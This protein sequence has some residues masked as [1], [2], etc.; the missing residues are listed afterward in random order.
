M[1]WGFPAS[2]AVKQLASINFN[3]AISEIVDLSFIPVDTYLEFYVKIFN[4]I[5]PHTVGGSHDMKFQ[6]TRN[7]VADNGIGAGGSGGYAGYDDV[8]A[9]NDGSDPQ[10]MTDADNTGSQDH[11]RIAKIG[12]AFFGPNPKEFTGSGEF[13]INNICVST[14]LRAPSL[15]YRMRFHRIGN[16]RTNGTG[17]FTWGNGVKIVSDNIAERKTFNGF[18]IY[19]DSVDTFTAGIKIYG[20]V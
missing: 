5:F 4:L 11:F 1:T 14:A 6:F 8:G 15:S 17:R 13:W 16:T 10:H 7:G 2:P 18:R 19:N 20:L 3:S 12:S 9:N